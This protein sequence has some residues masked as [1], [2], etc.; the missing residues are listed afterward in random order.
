MLESTS[1]PLSPKA[2]SETV[3][4]P[5]ILT[6]QAKS[7]TRT[8]KV[9]HINES[10]GILHEKSHELD[11]TSFDDT[12]TTD[13]SETSSTTTRKRHFSL[14]DSNSLKIKR[15]RDLCNNDASQKKIT[16]LFR[17]PIQYLSSRRRTLNGPALNRSL[18]SSVMSSSGIFDVDVVENLSCCEKLDSTP[19]SDKRKSF[20][21][22]SIKKN[23]FSR[24]FKSNKFKNKSSKSKTGNLNDSR[25]SE[26]DGRDVFNASCISNISNNFIPG[27]EH[28]LG[29]RSRLDAPGPSLTHTLVL[30]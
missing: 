19:F 16:S 1:A 5:S 2:T 26:I 11:V 17:T 22:K 21:D 13:F 29:T 4:T 8:P 14:Y 25:Y 15:K 9:L 24:T 10:L 7:L 27:N 12:I 6:N 28:R 23:L 3:A 20:C 18:N 30:T